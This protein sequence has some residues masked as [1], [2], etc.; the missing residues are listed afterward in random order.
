M[1][2]VKMYCLATSVLLDMSIHIMNVT[3]TGRVHLRKKNHTVICGVPGCTI[4]FKLSH[5][6]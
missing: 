4:F 3:Q 5:T 1:L 6:S 2:L